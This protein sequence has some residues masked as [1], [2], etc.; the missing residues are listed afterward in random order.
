M[1]DAPPR[2]DAHSANQFHIFKAV[3]RRNKNFIGSWYPAPDPRGWR[4]FSE[5]F[6]RTFGSAPPRIATLSYDALTMA[7]RLATAHPAGR[8][9]TTANLTRPNGFV[10]VDGAFRFTTAGTAQHSLAVLEVQ[11][12][13]PSV[14]DPAA[15]GFAPAG[16][17]ATGALQN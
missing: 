16:R 13:T 8:R 12:F 14:V 7:I 1:Q 17:V 4:A 3:I 5:K 2:Q 6:A 11:Q 9:Y 15:P 10:G